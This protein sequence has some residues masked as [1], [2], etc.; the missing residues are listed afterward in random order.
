MHLVFVGRELP[1]VRTLLGASNLLLSFETSSMGTLSESRLLTGNDLSRTRLVVLRARFDIIVLFSERL[2][3]IYRSIRGLVV[4]VLVMTL[5]MAKVTF[6]GGPVTHIGHLVRM[7][8]LKTDRQVCGLIRVFGTNVIFAALG[9]LGLSRTL[10]S[11][12][13][14]VVGGV[15]L[16]GQG[17]S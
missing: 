11:D 1:S 5:F 3:I 10:A 14:A 15:G 12:A 2:V 8:G 16:V 17:V 7:I 6:S 9:R 13:R 4:C